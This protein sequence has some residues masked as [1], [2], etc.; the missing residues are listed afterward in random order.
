MQLSLAGRKALVT[1]ASRGIGRAIA[2]A[3]GEAGADLALVATNEGLLEE[4][5]APLREQGRT[6]LVCPC[7]LSDGEAVAATVKAAAKELGGLDVVVNN[8]GITRDGLLMRHAEADWQK[9]FDVNLGGALRVTKAATRF[10]LK[11]PAGR[12]INISSVVGLTGNAG[13]ASYSASKAGL[14]GFTKSMAQELAS[15]GVTVNAVA[16]GFIETDMT[17][18]LTDEQQGAIKER[19]PLGRIGRV[20]EIAA[21]CAFLASEHAGYITGTV[22]RIDGGLSM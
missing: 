16:P 6:V 17:A 18:E 22:V 10:L 7:D 3:L 11:S 15:R 1:G 2:L 4:L 5:A 20:E 12:I 14:I 13:Q 19:I 21:A 8:A 9:V